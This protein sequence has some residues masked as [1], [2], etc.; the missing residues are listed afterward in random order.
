MGGRK[1]ESLG[2]DI[3]ESSNGVFL[4]KDIASKLD[5]DDIADS[6][7]RTDKYYLAVW[8]RVEKINDPIEFRKALEQIAKELNEGTFPYK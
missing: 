4:S 6:T 1:L 5:E 3:N 8:N 7:L 2:I